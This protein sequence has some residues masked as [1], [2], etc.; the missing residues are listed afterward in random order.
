MYENELNNVASDF[1]EEMRDEYLNEDDNYE[2]PE[3]SEELGCWIKKAKSF[4]DRDFAEKYLD[5]LTLGVCY[6]LNLQNLEQDV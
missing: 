4:T 2:E 6:P 3:Y 5:G 1:I